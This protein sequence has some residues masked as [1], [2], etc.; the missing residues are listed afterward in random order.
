MKAMRWV[1]VLCVVLGS[2]V[3]AQDSVDV[4]FRFKKEGTA[5]GVSVP[6]Q[7]NGWNN[8]A[9]P[10]VYQGDS[11]WTRTV[12]MNVGGSPSPIPGAHQYKFFFTGASPWPNDAFNHHVNAADNDNTFIIVKN[13]TIY[14]FLPNQRNPLVNTSTPAIT[15]YIFPLAGSTFD[16]SSLSMKIDA[17][18]YASLGRFYNFTTK[19]LTFVPPTPLSNGNHTAIL[20]AGST[21][22]TVTFITQAGFV[23]ITSQGGYSTRKNIIQVRGVVQNTSLTSVKLVRNNLDTTVVAVTSGSYVGADTLTE[24]LNTFK[25][26]ADS[27]GTRRVSDPIT[28]TYIV[29]HTPFGKVAATLAGSQVSLSAAGSTDPDGQALTNFRWLDDPLVPLGLNGLTGVSVSITKPSL[30]GEYYF[31]LIVTDPTGNADTSRHYFIVNAD[32]T[33]KNP[34]I[35]SSPEW[36]KKSRVYF[37]FPKGVSSSGTL[38]AAA[39][40]L[41]NIRDLGFNVIWLMPVMKNAFP[42]D[43][44]F[45]PGYNIV[46]FYNV[47]PEYGTNT[48]FRNFVSQAHTLGL[49]VILDVTPNHTSRSHPWAQD[50]RQFG[51]NSRYWGWYQH[52]LIPHNTNGLGQSADPYNFWYYSG[53]SDQLLNFDWTDVDARTEMTNVYKYWIQQFGL[54][55]YRFDV[56]WGPH[57]RYGEVNMGNPVRDA[58]KHIKPDIMLLGED[59]GTGSGTETIYADYTSGG[60]NGGVDAAYDFKLYFNQIRGY[61]ST[62]NITNLHNEIDNG[63][64]YPGENA[65]Y[66]RFMESQDEDR[67]V[68][69]YSNNN[70][71]DAQ[72]AFKRSMPMASVVFTSP[73][74]PMLWN[75]QEVGFGYGINGAKE[76]RSRSVINWEYQGKGLLSPHYQKLAHIRSQF[77]AFTQ[78][79]LDTNGDGQVN[80]ADLPDFVRVGSTNASV[81]AFSRP[82]LNQNGVTVANFTAADQTA[83]LDLT[84]ANTVKFTGGIVPGTTYYVNNLYMNTRQQVLGSQLSALSITVPA[85]GTAIYTISTTVDSVRIP[86]PI[87]DVKAVNTETPN[88]FSLAQNYPNPFNPSTRI[89][90]SLKE[91]GFASLKVFD[92]L[93]RE[94]ATLVNEQLVA[95]KY[96]VAFDARGLSSGVYFYKL[97]SGAFVET[98]KMMLTK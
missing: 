35:A 94:A 98:K 81:Y 53:F 64:F 54:D 32:G 39:L 7:F 80:S 21:V 79:K 68:Y 57:R 44:N 3:L 52:A 66:M 86:N 63:G 71:L 13:P 1:I 96:V 97:V 47:A 84:V 22:D 70:A 2:Q 17:T 15:A 92:I 12:R 36:A 9:M 11:L 41:Q 26:V 88:E 25:A 43:N 60:I 51:E 31:G 28:F 75:G 72:T 8:T 29:N 6:G 48:D 95:G 73:G 49:K 18:T 20:Q 67:I 23:Q 27:S 90:F 33:I 61:Y 45:G 38:N 65:L 24:G 37:L 59:D 50:A 34:T 87:L 5:T 58:L 76:A 77:D 19:Q 62:G 10:M 91:N 74:F 82:Y 55:G 69:F 89:S 40:R 30:K 83:Q 4:I 42:I 16:T 14:H 78:H 93:G 56:Y 46:D 85:Y